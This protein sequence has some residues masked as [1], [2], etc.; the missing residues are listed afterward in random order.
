MNRIRT[1]YS[2]IQYVPDS[3]RAEGANAGVVLFVPSASPAER[4]LVRTSPTLERVRQF[5]KPPKTQLRRVEFNVESLKHRLEL[6]RAEF[7]NEG[8]FEHFVATRADVVR[9]TKP[10][11][12]VVTDPR[13][14]FDELYAELV[15]DP[16]IK[17]RVAPK[18]VPLP[19]RVAE[20]FG[21]LEAERKVWRPKPLKVPGVRR[22]F[23]VS[24]AYQNGVTNYVRTESLTD[25]NKAEGRLPQLGFNGQLIHQKPI[26]NNPGR[27]VVMST[28]SGAEPD[29]EKRFRE[30][31]EAFHVRFVPYAEAEQFA[32]EV[33]QTAH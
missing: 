14:E 32:E 19:W 5:F 26:N 12:A 8:Q 22:A 20:V 23:E 31:L 28:D 16:D 33:A 10:K 13:A 7:E 6:A 2:I 21:R 24:L 25:R 18:H 9:L 29:I 27:L 11:L 17:E 4:I 3:G 15:G 30:T 1:L